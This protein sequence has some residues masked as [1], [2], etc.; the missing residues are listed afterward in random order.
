M[1]L[2][3]TI[4]NVKHTRKLTGKDPAIEAAIRWIRSRDNSN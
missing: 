2:K 3:I 4:W 1:T